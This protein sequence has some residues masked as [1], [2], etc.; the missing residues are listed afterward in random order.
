MITAAPGDGEPSVYVRLDEIDTVDS[1]P[2]TKTGEVE[3]ETSLGLIDQAS[4]QEPDEISIEELRTKQHGFLR[5]VFACLNFQLLLTAGWTLSCMFV[6]P[7]YAFMITQQARHIRFWSIMVYIVVL[8]GYRYSSQIVRKKYAPGLLPLMTVANAVIAGFIGA[9]LKLINLEYIALGVMG[10]III[11]TLGL[12]AFTIQSK[13]D[14]T[15]KY[16]IAF[17]F[18]L[19]TT[20]TG[21]FVCIFQNHADGMI[22]VGIFTLCFALILVYRARLISL[23]ADLFEQNDYILGALVLFIRANHICLVWYLVI[24]RFY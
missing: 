6:D 14:F 2:Q 13:Y 19:D 17:V 12:T 21:L 16:A 18:I 15:S 1:T 3:A 20:T 22:C 7:I 10:M 8:L 11:M 5:K 24:W 23:K 9:Y 4:G